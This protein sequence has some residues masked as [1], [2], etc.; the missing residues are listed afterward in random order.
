MLEAVITKISAE[1]PDL[2]GRV[3]GAV[4]FGALVAGGQ[5]PAS[6]YAAFVIPAG[7][8]GRAAEAAAGSFVQSFDE[9]IGVVVTIRSFEAAA[10]RAVDPLRELVRQVYECLCGWAPSDEVGVLVLRAGRLL[11]MQAGLIVYQLDFT[12]T[13]QMRIAR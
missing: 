7:L 6:T 10:R 12:L 8:N 2:A 4:D 5:M 1:V 9:T 13:D 3:S 11:S